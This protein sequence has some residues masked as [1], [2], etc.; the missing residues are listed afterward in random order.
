MNPSI[1]PAAPA[2][3]QSASLY[4]GDLHSEITEGLLFEL[5][6]RVGPVASIRVCRDAVTRRSLGY[7]YVNFHNVQDAER[8]LDTMNFTDIKGRPCRIMWSQRDPSLR[9]SG[10]GNVFVK[11]LAPAVDNKGLFD[12]FSVFGNI[13]SC[14]VATDEAGVSKGYGYVHYETAEA[15]QEAIAKF[16]GNYIEDMEVYVGAFVRRQDRAGQNAW[17]NLYVKQFP[18]SWTED[19]LRDL[20]TRFGPVANVIISRDAEGN[21]RA[22]GFVN[23]ADHESAEAAVKELHSKLI[24]DATTGTST[25]LY[26]NR[27]QKKVE[28]SREIKSKMDALKEERVSKYQG[29]N[30]YVKNID[31]SVTDEYFREIF[32]KYGTITSARIMRDPV[33]NSSKGFGFICY[34]SP[35]EAA[36]AVTEQNSKLLRS[37]PLLVTLHQRKDL[38]RAHLAATY[39]PR[40]MRFPAGGPSGMPAMPFMPMYGPGAQSPFPRGPFPFPQQGPGY[41]PRGGNGSPRG[42]PYGGRGQG[43]PSPPGGYYPMPYPPQ[44]QGMQPPQGY[45]RSRLPGPGPNQPMMGGMPMQQQRPGGRPMGGP[46][47]GRGSPGRQQIQQPF[48]Q[49]LGAPMPMGGPQ[50]QGRQPVK[51]NSNARN[52]QGAAMGHPGMMPH[53]GM[54]PHPAMLAS[55]PMAQSLSGLDDQALAQADPQMQKNMIGER[56]YPLIYSTQPAL[57]GKITGML[58]EMDN[59]E[60]LNLIE[61]PDAL[62]NKIEEALVVLNNHHVAEE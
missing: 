15:A 30:L 43:P 56:L 20:F 42:M 8:A 47:G 12:I 4:V 9:K 46:N 11:N 6:N 52:Q 50:M 37:K 14:K 55:Q 38:R 7:A 27:A 41:A 21:S 39:A 5:F 60:L 45:N 17:T 59:A 22:F 16:N 28:R 54:M 3:F 36:L 2:P 53:Q 10:V 24:D 62:A 40:N 33:D 57:A 23:F 26:V 25:E 18:A 31:D 13:L 35:E 19:Q 29:M 44:M 58:L 51:F 32:S 1:P 49:Q 61:S 48:M 34:S